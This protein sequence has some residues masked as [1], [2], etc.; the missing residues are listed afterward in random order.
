M[1]PH[2]VPTGWPS[3]VPYLTVT[4]ADRLV[5]FLKAALGAEEIICL[6]E[7]DGRIAHAAFWVHGSVIELSEAKPS[8]PFVHRPGSVHLFVP[9]VDA[10]YQAALAAGAISLTEPADAFYGERGASV[11]DPVGNYW[12]FATV[13]EDLSAEEVKRRATEKH[14]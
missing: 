2:Y 14:G 3:A 13:I 7:P 12:H 10:T 9:D 5:T 6:A 1:K 8:P 4:G 11:E